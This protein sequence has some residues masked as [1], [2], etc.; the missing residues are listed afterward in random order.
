MDGQTDG[1]NNIVA[2]SGAPRVAVLI[3]VFNAADRLA[4]TLRSV[5]V[6][7]GAFDIFVVDDGSTPPLRIDPAD[8]RHRI[9]LIRLDTNRGIVA[10]LNAGLAEIMAAD[11]DFV[12]R[13]DAGD[14]DIG[15]RIAR[16]VA[17]LSAEPSLAVVGCWTEF[18]DLAGSDGYVYRTPLD[19]TAIRRRMHFSPSFI[20]PACTI[21]LSALRQVGV[22]SDRYRHA[23]DY[24]L[25]FRLIRAF[26][27]RNLPEILVASEINPEGISSA[28]RRAALV[29]RIRIQLRYFSPASPYSYIGLLRSLVFLLAPNSLLLRLKLRRKVV[30]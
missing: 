24:D 7:D 16:Q 30:N 12:V 13:H 2:A 20:H 11:Y 3:P 27:T 17:V 23:E 26:P 1:R 21:R 15:P 4:R 25:F 8:Y 19:E 9:R 6:Q 5:D 14:V 28:S 22:Y 29:S 10:A 18:V